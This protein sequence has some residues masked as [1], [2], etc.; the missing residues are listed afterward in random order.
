MDSGSIGT[1]VSDRLVRTLGLTTEQRPLST[2]K[3]ADGGQLQC[4]HRVPSLQWWIQGQTFKS[5][6]K[7]LNLRCYDMIIGEDWLEV[8]S[9]VW[10]DYKSKA[11]R[12]THLGKRVALQGVKDQLDSC[13]PISSKKLQGLMKHGGVA[14]CLQLVSTEASA[15]VSDELQYICTI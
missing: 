10:V 7:V 9:P 15:K 2:F 13:P 14:C 8:V 11:M 12:I 6:A 4:S 5:D 3:A 1:F